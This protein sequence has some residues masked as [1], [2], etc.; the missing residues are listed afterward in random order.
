MHLRP[1]QPGDEHALTQLFA[2]VFA[3]PMSVAHWRWKLLHASTTPN[4]FLATDDA[5][6]AILQY[7]AIPARFL[8]DGTARDGMISV[9]TMTAPEHRK[10]GLLTHAGREV[11]DYWRTAGIELV[12]GIP[13]ANWGSR[14]RYLGWRFLL[15]LRC[16]IRPLRPLA[17]LLARAR[18]S[19]PALSAKPSRLEPLA[20]AGAELDELWHRRTASHPGR[21]SIIRDARWVRWRFLDAPGAPYSLFALRRGTALRGYGVLRV[22]G[23]LAFVPELV[24]EDRA[25]RRELL[26]GLAIEA[27]RQGA[28]KIQ[29]L[30]P[31][32]SE[33]ERDLW[34]SG[35][36]VPRDRFDVKV[37]PLG[38]H[39]TELLERGSEWDVM[40][41][42]FDFQ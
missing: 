13:N 11:Y 25:T 7:A 20:H 5:N 21:S 12:L 23:D 14:D 37:V 22:D 31:E 19:L 2:R 38:E 16:W 40:G 39:A 35:F 42:D 24:A 36:V 28:L 29:M 1:Y 26:T 34:R 4:V 3:K 27:R 30:A 8:L 41:S 6:N 32:S 15:R 10:K 33:L 17:I 18:I 9:D